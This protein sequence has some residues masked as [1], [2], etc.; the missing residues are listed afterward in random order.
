MHD[1][2]A[3]LSSFLGFPALNDLHRQMSASDGSMVSEA[4]WDSDHGTHHERQKKKK[5]QASR[6]GRGH[7]DA[8]VRT[9]S[10]KPLKCLEIRMAKQRL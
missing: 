3:L 7:G 10:A 5:K 8:M 2:N 6:A 4:S 1:T 9:C